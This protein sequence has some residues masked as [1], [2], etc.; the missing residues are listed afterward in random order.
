[1]T[2]QVKKLGPLAL[3]ALFLLNTGYYFDLAMV[4]AWNDIY[5]YYADQPLA[6]LDFVSTGPQ[7]FVFIGTL[8]CAALIKKVSKKTILVV[9]YGLFAIIGFIIGLVDNIYYFALMR[10]LLGLAA[11]GLL[12]VAVAIITEYYFNEPKKLDALVGAYNGFGAL[13]GAAITLIAGFLCVGA[14]QG[15][16]K[17]YWVALPVLVL[18]ILFVPKTPAERDQETNEENASEGSWLKGNLFATLVGMFMMSLFYVTTV[19][20]ISFFVFETGL[21]DAALVGGFSSAMTLA[22]ALGAFSFPLI[23]QYL[24]RATPMLFYGCTAIGFLLFFVQ[25]NII[26]TGLAVCLCGFAYSLSIPYYMTYAARIVPPARVS[27]SI[28]FV[29]AALAIGAAISA[30][31]FSAVIGLLGWESHAMLLPYFGFGVLICCILAVVLTIR[32][33][34]RSETDSPVDIS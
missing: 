25:G 32:S 31:V 28:T 16:F 12:P 27:T 2:E 4:P 3:A 7:F 9:C 30:Y 18:L 19:I 29:S 5:A 11:G 20:Q 17:T 22:G 33:K 1:M 10:S 13:V 15:V 26:V 24:K 23:N 8:I 6:M 34:T 14:W 21:G